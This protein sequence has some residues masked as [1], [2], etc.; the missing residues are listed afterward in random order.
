MLSG[1]ENVNEERLREPDKTKYGIYHALQSAVSISP[2]CCHLPLTTK[3]KPLTN[4]GT[5]A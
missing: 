2:E 3:G 1:K 5:T 4:T